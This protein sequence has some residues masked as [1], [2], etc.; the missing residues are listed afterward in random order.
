MEI[1]EMFDNIRSQQNQVASGDGEMF[2]ENAEFKGYPTKRTSQ[3]KTKKDDTTVSLSRI[4][5]EYSDDVIESFRVV[6]VFKEERA[7][8]D[9]WKVT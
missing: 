9:T 5:L 3:I 1:V 6:L 4:K 8:L 2:D 7:F